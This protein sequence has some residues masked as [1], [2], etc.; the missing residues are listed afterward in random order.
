MTVSLDVRGELRIA[1]EGKPQKL[2]IKVAASFAYDEMRVGDSMPQVNRRAARFYRT[3]QADIEIAKQAQKQILRDSRRLILVN[4]AKQG[5]V[6]SSSGGPLWREELDLIDVQANSLLIDALLPNGEVS[7][8]DSWAPD[9]AMTARLLGLDVVAENNVNCSLGQVS[10]TTA[11]IRIAG[12]LTGAAAGVASEI[13]VNGKAVFDLEQKRLVSIQLRIKERRSTGFVSPG[14]DVVADLKMDVAPLA[15]SDQLGK[16][17]VEAVAADSLNLLPPLE[18]MS[19]PGAFRLLYDRRW[20]VTRDEPALAVLRLLDRGELIAQCN[21]SPLD[22]VPVESRFTLEH[23]QEEVQ[24][25]LGKNFGQIESAAER[26]TAHGLRLLRVVALGAVSG[27]PI[28]WRYY[29]AI[30]E[31]G[32]RVAF[33]YTLESKL[34][35]QFADADTMMIDSLEFAKPLPTPKKATADER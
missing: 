5:I 11:D 32:R 16:E 7:I 2:P 12:H 29:L 8:G 28:E 25:A 30:D 17:V 26:K 13:D 4:S 3:A 19:A 27:L 6:I 33:T 20:H 24:Q 14:F 18:F 1:A 35:E 10:A 31:Q 23:F 15:G 22:P 34:A 9:S 21:I